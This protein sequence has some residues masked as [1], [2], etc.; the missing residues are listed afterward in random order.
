MHRTHGR[1]ANNALD[2]TDQTGDHGARQHGVPVEAPDLA[3]SNVR[4]TKM[5]DRAT[6]SEISQALAKAIAYRDCGKPAD[7][8]AWATKLVRMLEAQEILRPELVTVYNR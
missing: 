1:H 3:P 5:T 2:S 4:G 7:A 6:R 8:A